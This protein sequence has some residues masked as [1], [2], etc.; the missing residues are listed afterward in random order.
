MTDS[1]KIVHV[2]VAVIEQQGKVLIAKRP[3]NVH[4]GGFWEFPGGKV[5]AGETVIQALRRELQEELGI[6]IGAQHALVKIKHDYAD[7]S[8][9]LDVWKVTAFDGQASGLEGQPVRW[10]FPDA[11]KQ[12]DFPAANQPIIDAAILPNRYLITPEPD[13]NNLPQFLSQ[14]EVALSS[15]IKLAQF[16][17]KQLPESLFAS[18]ITQVKAIAE[19]QSVELF[20][21]C[22]IPI[23]LKYGISKVHLSSNALHQ[24]N[25]PIDGL[26]LAASCHNAEEIS[27]AQQ[28]G[29]RFAVLSCVKKTLSHPD[30]PAMG[31]DTFE[32][33]CLQAKLPVYAL[34]GMELSDLETSSHR[35]AQGIASISSFWPK[36]R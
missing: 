20:I 10:V 16:R 11:L 18:V 29:A 4:Q 1:H 12:Y 15:D 13:A 28:I 17:A 19:N 24:V 3:Q 25:A 33:L 8:V 6:T 30:S 36:S 14:F 21:N 5:E 35:G 22:N 27:K 34:G 7:E 23:A 9:L 31:W 2:A 32:S 26:E